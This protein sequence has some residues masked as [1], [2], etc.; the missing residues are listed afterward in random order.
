[1][2]KLF[3]QNPRTSISTI[4]SLIDDGTIR[5]WAYNKLSNGNTRLDWQ[6]GGNNWPNLDKNVYF[7]SEINIED[8]NKKFI[9]FVLHTKKGHQLN[10]AD[11][12]QMH[13][14]LTGMLFTHVYANIRASI[15]FKAEKDAYKADVI[16]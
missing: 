11:Y 6:G 13:S 14:E 5:T 10:E 4:K 8:K 7:E 9:L 12:A 2:L 16:D 1:M 3:T 15:V